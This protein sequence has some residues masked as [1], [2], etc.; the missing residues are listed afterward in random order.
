MQKNNWFPENRMTHI[1]VGMSSKE[2][3]ADR[4]TTSSTYL[5]IAH[6]D[7]VSCTV[8]K[9]IG[10]EHDP[11]IWECVPTPTMCPASQFVAAS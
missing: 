3:V 11:V 5:K 1:Q 10:A 4:S 9:E 2:A 8:K 6:A 7:L